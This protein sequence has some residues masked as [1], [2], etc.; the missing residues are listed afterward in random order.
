MTKN[1]TEH[2]LQLLSEFAKEKAK[3][4][5]RRMDEYLLDKAIKSTETKEKE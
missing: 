2:E 4:I 5:N 1:I 3:E